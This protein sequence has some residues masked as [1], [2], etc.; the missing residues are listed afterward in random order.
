MSAVK[1]PE[2]RPGGVHEALRLTP[3][4]AGPCALVIFGAAGDLTRRLLMPSLYHLAADRLL[5]DEFA[6]IGFARTH[7]EENALRDAFRKSVHESEPPPIDEG[8][9]EWL[10]SR[11]TYVSAAFDDEAGWDRLVGVLDDVSRRYRIG[12]NRLFYLATAPEHFL[13]ICERLAARR[14]L[15]EQAR[16]YRRVVI[17][18]PFGHDLESARALNRRLLE[19]MHEWQIYRIDHYLGKETVQNI[20]V[21]RFGNGIFEP[22]WNR[23]YIDHVQITV[24]EKIGVES[25]GEYYDRTGALRDMVPN[26]LF[27]LLTFAAMEP[28]SSFS[29]T[30]LHNEQV[31]VLEAVEPLSPEE[32]GRTTLRAQYGPG[33]IDGR[34][35]PGYRQ[36]PHVSPTSRTE[37]YAA[38]RLTV[39]NWRWAGVPFY[40]RT[41][42]RLAAKKSEVVIQFRD[43]PLALFRQASVELPRAANRLVISIQPEESISL[44]LAAKVPGPAIVIAPVHMRFEYDDY[45]GVDRRTGYETLLYEAMIGDRSLF[46]RSDMIERGWAIVQPILDAWRADVCE[47]VEYP[48]GSSGPVEADELIARDGRAWRPLT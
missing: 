1:A 31:K 7:I 12:G 48:A 9:L 8:R 11:F 25:R 43:P 24:A 2:R 28:P 17:E 44:E 13:P 4:P 21:F 40:L 18:K 34:P 39:D 36:E 33:E 19:L 15:E 29:S 37:T 45:F 20:L 46:K 41:G 6:V 14:L 30:A 47:L 42:K 22:V 16:E 32:C 23:R 3:T 26:H 10:L 27:Q 35:V 38:L 5:S